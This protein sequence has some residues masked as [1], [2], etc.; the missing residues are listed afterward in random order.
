MTAS[1]TILPVFGTRQPGLLDSPRA[2]RDF[3]RV[4][5]QMGIL[6]TANGLIRPPQRDG[7]DRGD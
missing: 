4:C 3:V 5:R 1:V 7:A 6:D 2:L